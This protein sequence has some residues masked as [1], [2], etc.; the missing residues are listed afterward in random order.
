MSGPDG[1]ET[2]AAQHD[3]LGYFAI[4]GLDPNGA[5]T[6]AAVKASYWAK[7]KECYPG[8]G[9]DN[10]DAKRFDT[11]AKAR[12]A[13][14]TAQKRKMYRAGLRLDGRPLIV[15]VRVTPTYYRPRRVRT[16]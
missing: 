10:P 4:L 16:V 7:A 12:E 6:D 9:V 2:V 13:L 14:E 3:L 11:L 5:V 1:G 15:Q 8:G